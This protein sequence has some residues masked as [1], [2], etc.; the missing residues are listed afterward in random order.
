P[1][2]TGIIAL[3]LEA[4]STLDA[5]EVKDILQRTARADNF[6][7]TVPNPTWGYGKVDAYAALT[8]ILNPS[9]ISD[10]ELNGILTQF[11]TTPN[12][13]E[14]HTDIS[15]VLQTSFEGDI[16][17]YNLQGQKVDILHKGPM[18]PGEQHFSW[19]AERHPAGMYIL[20][21][22]LE[23]RSVNRKVLKR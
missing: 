14:T 9:S 21:L 5:V 2:L 10:E 7:G 11:K 3:M 22:E 20:R 13:F 8:E 23:G 15:F 4:D 12:P 1:V 6:T 19:N 16:S 17:I 18:S